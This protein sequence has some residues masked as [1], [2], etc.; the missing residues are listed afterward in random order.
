MQ[1]IRKARD[2]VQKRLSE[3][4]KLRTRHVSGFVSSVTDQGWGGQHQ[5]ITAPEVQ[6]FVQSNSI[7][8]HIYTYMYDK[9]ILVITLQRH[10]RISLSNLMKNSLFYSGKSNKMLEITRKGVERNIPNVV[11][12]LYK[13]KYCKEYWSSIWIEYK[14]KRCKKDN[15][16]YQSYR[17]S[18]QGEIKSEKN[19]LRN[20]HLNMTIF[21]VCTTFQTLKVKSQIP[22]LI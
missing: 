21:Q 8:N 12:P 10:G 16:C 20:Q 11:I 3:A 1:L 2:N 17:S 22:R 6:L 13:L 15:K 18:V 5:M 9:G 19:I 4:G 7:T 14:Q